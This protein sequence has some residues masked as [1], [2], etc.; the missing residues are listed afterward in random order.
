[1]LAAIA[2]QGMI[3]AECT[4]AAFQQTD[5]RP[6]SACVSLDY[7]VPYCFYLILEVKCRMF[8]LAHGSLPLPEGSSLEGDPFP[9]G[10]L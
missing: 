7:A 5:T 8:T 2:C 4:P 10:A 3:R 1:M 6:R 9:F